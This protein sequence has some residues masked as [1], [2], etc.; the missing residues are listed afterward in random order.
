MFFERN[1][2]I[3]RQPCPVVCASCW[4]R[5]ESAPVRWLAS[6]EPR[7]DRDLEVRSVFAYGEPL[8]AVI[9]AA[10]NGG[11]RP[12][13]RQLGAAM[14]R[15]VVDTEHL[16]AI[17]WVPANAASR[18]VRGFDQGRLLARTLAAHLEIPARSFLERPP[19]SRADGGQKGKGRTER[20]GG[21]AFRTNR[22]VSGRLLLIDDVI[23]TGSSL[24]RA[25]D[26]LYRAGAHDVLAVTAA[27]ADRPVL[28]GRK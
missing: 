3:C 1:C 8:A 5:L 15:T 13:L 7:T 14:A 17:T 2:P 27:S 18:R 16:D 11:R 21:A 23:T 12:L 28:A 4:G 20:L 25:A 10:K 6:P 9:L 22:N 24:R 19:T 26:A